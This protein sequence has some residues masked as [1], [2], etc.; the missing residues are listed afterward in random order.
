MRLPRAVVTT[1]AL[2][3][4]CDEDKYARLALSET[5]M[6]QSP[7]EF[8]ASAIRPQ[9]NP[10][11]KTQVRSFGLGSFSFARVAK[12][13]FSSSVSKRKSISIFAH[14]RHRLESHV[15]HLWPVPHHRNPDLIANAQLVLIGRTAGFSPIGQRKNRESHSSHRNGRTKI[16]AK[17]TRS[18]S[19]SSTTGP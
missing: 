17:T 1:L 7:I 2:A 13:S 6:A 8:S 4:N 10:R 12:L 3:S 5:Y 14:Q 11:K 19:P 9:F 18:K 15:F 16:A